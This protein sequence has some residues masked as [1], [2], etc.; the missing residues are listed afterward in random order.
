MHFL[1]DNFFGLRKWALRVSGQIIILKSSSFESLKDNLANLLL[2]DVY[3]L[4]AHSKF[5]P[6]ILQRFRK[7]KE[8]PTIREIL[9]LQWPLSEFYQVVL[10]LR[11]PWLL[12]MMHSLITISSELKFNK[13]EKRTNGQLEMI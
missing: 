2:L 11:L 4:T 10:E 13:L 6:K 8:Y 9:I 1:E 3:E 5:G 12:S 7:V